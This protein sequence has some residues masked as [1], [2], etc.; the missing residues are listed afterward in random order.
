MAGDWLVRRE[1]RM[2]GDGSWRGVQNHILDVPDIAQT[3]RPHRKI[4]ASRRSGEYGERRTVCE[5]F[6][7]KIRSGKVPEIPLCCRREGDTRDES[8]TGAAPMRRG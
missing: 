1:G 6:G 2:D 8:S 7:Q 5:M 4:Q 3:V